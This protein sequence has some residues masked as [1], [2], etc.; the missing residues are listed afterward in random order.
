M[1]PVPKPKAVWLSLLAV[2]G[3]PATC[4]AIT[5]HDSR[6][7]EDQAAIRET[8]IAVGQGLPGLGYVLGQ[9]N[10]GQW[11]RA[12]CLVKISRNVAVTVAHATFHFQQGE[13]KDIRAGFVNPADITNLQTSYAV[14]AIH[15]HPI[16]DL[17]VIILATQPGE[18]VEDAPTTKEIPALGDL[19]HFGGYGIYSLAGGPNLSSGVKLGARGY[20]GEFSDPE[21]PP[22]YKFIE[23]AGDPTNPAYHPEGGLVDSGDSGGGVYVLDDTG[24]YQLVGLNAVRTG[25]NEYGEHSGFI[26]LGIPAAYRFTNQF[27][28]LDND[29]TNDLAEEAFGSIAYPSGIPTPQLGILT[30]QGSNTLTLTHLAIQAGTL[31]YQGQFSHDLVTWEDATPSVNPPGL[32]SPPANYQWLTW[33]TPPQS[34]SA[35]MRATAEPNLDPE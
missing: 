27:L 33:Q 17:A 9:L 11:I 34:K 21:I 25:L 23:F 12:G 28:D 2:A 30:A 26:P 20:L 10:D 3:L 7:E 18:D 32:P 35:F 22:Y 5:V 14:S 16:M 19:L 13:Y 15:R 31:T 4:P 8:A 6:T 29:G 24:H 1:K